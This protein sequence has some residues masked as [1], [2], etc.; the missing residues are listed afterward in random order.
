M[1]KTSTEYIERERYEINRCKFIV[2]ILR[3]S[4]KEATKLEDI[5]QIIGFQVSIDNQPTAYDVDKVVEQLKEANFSEDWINDVIY[6][7]DA[8]KIVKS[9]GID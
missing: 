3:K 6:T 7:K 8:V 4:Q 9:G 2:G 5:A 1:P